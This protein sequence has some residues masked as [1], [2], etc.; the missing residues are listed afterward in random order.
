MDKAL[1]VLLGVA[2][3]FAI[4]VFGPMIGVLAGAFSGWIVGWLA[5]VW[6]PA[7]LALLGFKVTAGELVYLGAA[8]GFFSGFFKSTQ[9]NNNKTD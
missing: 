5:P 6:V 8:L 4:I 3:V 2:G 7:G 9:A 1:A